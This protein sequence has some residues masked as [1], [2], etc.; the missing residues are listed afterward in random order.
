[1]KLGSSELNVDDLAWLE[2]WYRAQGQSYSDTG[3]KWLI[4][5]IHEN[6]FRASGDPGRLRDLVHA[7]RAW[8]SG[9]SR[10]EV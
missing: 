7:F 6:T 2:D 8:V 9:S 1:L 5:S 10:T 4:Y 3:P